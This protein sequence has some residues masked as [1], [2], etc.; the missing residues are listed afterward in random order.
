MEYLLEI[1]AI[2]D[3]IL[4]KQSS[5]EDIQILLDKILSNENLQYLC[6][7]LF[8]PTNTKVQQI[9]SGNI[10]IGQARDVQIGSRIYESP[11]VKEIQQAIYNSVSTALS[12]GFKGLSA[13]DFTGDYSIGNS[14]IYRHLTTIN[15]YSTLAFLENEFPE[16]LKTILGINTTPL[17]YTDNGV[18]NRLEDFTLNS[19]NKF[20][21]SYRFRG[22]SGIQYAINNSNTTKTGVSININ[23]NEPDKQ[24][25]MQSREDFEKD[26]L[27]YRP[28]DLDFEFAPIT[29]SFQ[30]TDEEREWTSIVNYYYEPERGTIL[31]Y[32]KLSAIK[33]IGKADSWIKKIINKN[34]DIR[35]LVL[36]EYSYIK[37]INTYF[38]MCAFNH[39]DIANY[40]QPTPYLRFV[41]IQNSQNKSIKIENISF[42][43][44]DYDDY[45]MT[46][47]D[48]RQIILDRGHK[49]TQNLNITLNPKQHLL[50]PIE[51][52]FDMNS[53]PRQLRFTSQESNPTLSHLLGNKIYVGQI[54]ESSDIFY[55]FLNVLNNK[56][57][58][59]EDFYYDYPEQ[60]NPLITKE[61]E[62]SQQ[63][64]AGVKSVEDLVNSVPRRFAIGSFMDIISLRID[65]E[66]V[67]IDSPND[68]PKF[69]MT[70]YYGYGSCPYLLVYNSKKGYWIEL[71][72]IFYGKARKILQCTEVYHLGDDISKIK[73]EER[74]KEITY[75]ESLSIIY[76]D[77][78]T[79]INQEVISSLTDLAKQ[80]EGYFVLHQGQSM[81]IN[82]E[83][84]IPA[85]AVNIKLKING[86]YEIL[87]SKP[88]D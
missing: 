68:T 18:L 76:T 38:N 49:I 28:A 50:I 29:A 41:D 9:G 48:N 58:R 35:G 87:N 13:S 56:N 72:T 52:G 34:P 1:Q 17:I 74:D 11:S 42:N 80:E 51:F 32:P 64:L 46:N 4:E 61:L 21:V 53:H 84:I 37:K 78:K 77:P 45:L 14:I 5:E 65:G 39:T 59:L 36:F 2:F 55:N 16:K 73:I 70:A 10:N 66:E 75:I 81:E 22:V 54:P 31:Q 33:T 20:L 12:E 82:L 7:K 57:I 79:S 3:R 44:A 83:N 63:F 23:D 60:I 86:Y 69:S 30:D 85:D 24:G 25:F 88:R 43:V 6:E 67:I 27:N 8:I 47:V 26:I 71:G 62:L 40:I 15:D 19:G